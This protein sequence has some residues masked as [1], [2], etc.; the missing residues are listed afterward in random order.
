MDAKRQ[1]RD[2]QQ[3]FA[4]DW[5]SEAPMLCDVPVRDLDKRDEE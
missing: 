5:Y 2:L 1:A 4:I 3:I